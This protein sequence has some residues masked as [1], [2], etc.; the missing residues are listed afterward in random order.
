MLLIK[1]GDHTLELYSEGYQPERRH[2]SVKTGGEVQRLT[3]LFTT[4]VHRTDSASSRP[5]ARRGWF[6]NPWLWSAVGVVVAGAATGTALA[7][8]GNDSK[9]ASAQGGSTAVV[10]RSP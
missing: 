7:L 3:V 4:P 1:L 9:T 8:T 5:A 10:L 6:R 2:V